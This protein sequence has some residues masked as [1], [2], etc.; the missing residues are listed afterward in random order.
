MTMQGN[1][2]P[3]P[4]ATRPDLRTLKEKQANPGSQA[5]E[6]DMRKAKNSTGTVPTCRWKRCQHERAGEGSRYCERHQKER[7]ALFITVSLDARAW[8][9]W[10]RPKIRLAKAQWQS[11]QSIK[12]LI[13]M[14]QTMAGEVPGDQT[15]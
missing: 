15:P 5:Q 8:V 7:L 12:R 2:G 6:Q 3:S 9:P 14:L 4:V 1:T 11:E 10:L 13:R